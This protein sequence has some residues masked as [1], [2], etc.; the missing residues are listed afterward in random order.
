MKP[1]AEVTVEAM[2]DTFLTIAEATQ[3][4][5]RSASTIRRLIR[6]IADVPDHPDRQGI[7]PTEK[8]VETLKKKGENFTWRI[9]EDILMRDLETAQRDERKSSSSSRAHLQDEAL[10]ILRKELEIKNQQIEK[11]LDVIQSLN[12]RL[13]EGNILMGSLQQRL[14]LPAAEAPVPASAMEAFSE[15]AKKVSKKAKVEA[16]QKE[17]AAPSAAVSAKP[18]KKRMLGWIFG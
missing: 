7:E 18:S 8:E 5:G 1:S 13:R 15:A 3:K 16:M 14:S 6:T 12:E 11:Q 17:P 10:G 9:R 4:T 2:H